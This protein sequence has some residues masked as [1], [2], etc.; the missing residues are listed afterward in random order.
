MKAPGSPAVTGVLQ[1]S[2]VDEEAIGGT[3]LLNADNR[4][5]Q[6]YFLATR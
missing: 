6:L 4:S 2:R 1:L 3:L 5:Y